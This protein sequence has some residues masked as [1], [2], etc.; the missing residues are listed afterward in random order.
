MKKN[1]FFGDTLDR[2]IFDTLR[3]GKQA[4][5]FSLI[6]VVM[7]VGVMSFAILPLVALL[8]VG[9]RTVQDSM[10]LTVTA[11]IAQQIR[12][13]LQQISF[14]PNDAVNINN[15]HSQVYYYTNEGIKTTPGDPD[16]YYNATFSVNGVTAASASFTSTNAQTVTVTL[17]YP[18][19]IPAARQTKKVFPLLAAR[20]RSVN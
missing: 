18:N 6:E 1:A 15:L 11:G 8:P 13:E 14:N 17:A 5:G 4:R 7:A 2:L 10:D 16:V 9:L 20:Q 3:H 12:G 19:A